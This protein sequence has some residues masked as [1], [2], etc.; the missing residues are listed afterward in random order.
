MEF[1]FR[2]EQ[3]SDGQLHSL[4]FKL[5]LEIREPVYEYGFL[6]GNL[7]LTIHLVVRQKKLGHLCGMERNLLERCLDGSA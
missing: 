6:V 2:E 3:G 7:G 4:F 1:S 5:L